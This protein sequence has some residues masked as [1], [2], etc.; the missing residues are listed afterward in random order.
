MGENLGKLEGES[1]WEKE[2]NRVIKWG[3]IGVKLGVNWG[4]QIG[5]RGN[6]GM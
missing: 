6:S 1:V 4:K 2:G 3:K 5:V